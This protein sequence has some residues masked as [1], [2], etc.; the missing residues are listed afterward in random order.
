MG[1]AMLER[2][3]HVTTI[4]RDE[5]TLDL[6]GVDHTW[7]WDDDDTKRHFLCVEDTTNRPQHDIE[8]EAI[9]LSIAKALGIEP[10]DLWQ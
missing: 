7:E 5:S 2:I 10:M 1:L 6:E 9:E 3:V 4:C 8:F